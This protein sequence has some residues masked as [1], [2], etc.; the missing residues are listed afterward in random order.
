MEI[1]ENTLKWDVLVRRHFV[2]IIV[3]SYARHSCAILRRL[4]QREIA[5]GNG[6]LSM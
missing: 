1:P 3:I 2:Y 5:S 6:V 4:K